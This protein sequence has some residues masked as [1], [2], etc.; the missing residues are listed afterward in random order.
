MKIEF[1]CEYNCIKLIPK[2]K[3]EEVQFI[4]KIQEIY[5][6][7]KH[8][9]FEPFKIQHDISDNKE[10][11]DKCHIFIGK[12]IENFDKITALQYYYW[13]M[14]PSNEYPLF[15]EWERLWRQTK[16]STLIELKMIDL[17]YDS[18]YNDYDIKDYSILHH[19][20]KILQEYFDWKSKQYDLKLKEINGD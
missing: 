17:K 10:L 9:H 13:A 3:D 11:N 16:I 7:I 18:D 1:K 20:D 19:K 12:L 8:N 2:N 5:P 15:G 14:K 4:E 6:V